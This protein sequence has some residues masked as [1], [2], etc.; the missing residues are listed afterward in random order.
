[1]SKFI[2]D[3]KDVLKMAAGFDHL[4]ASFLMRELCGRAPG[5]VL[6]SADV[7]VIMGRYWSCIREQC[8]CKKHRN[9]LFGE[10]SG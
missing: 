7:L 2:L 9:N 4:A 5:M 1:M 8:G 6:W 3:A 10:I